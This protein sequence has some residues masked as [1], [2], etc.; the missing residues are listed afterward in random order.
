MVDVKYLEKMAI[1][2]AIGMANLGFLVIFL[3]LTRAVLE[4]LSLS[5]NIIISTVTPAFILAFFT[6]L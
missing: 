2:Y 5:R 4:P 6:R 1:W 3:C